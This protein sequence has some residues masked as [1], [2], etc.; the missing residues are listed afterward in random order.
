MPGQVQVQMLAQVGEAYPDLLKLVE[1]QLP[2]ITVDFVQASDFMNKALAVAAAGTPPDFSQGNARYVPGMVEGKLLQDLGPLVSRGSFDVKDDAKPVLTDLSWKG[3]LYGL[4]MDL[5]FAYIAYNKDLFKQAGQTDPGTLWGGGKWTWDAFVAAAQALTTHPGG[6]P[7]VN[8]F[9]VNNWEGD[10]LSFIRSLGGDVLNAD[11]TTFVLDSD[12][13]ITALTDWAGLVT[14]YKVSPPPADGN[15]PFEKV[16][17][18]MASSNPAYIVPF[19]KAQP[20]MAWDL[21][22]YPTLP[23]GTTRPVLFSNGYSLWAGA[24]QQQGA[25][26]VMAALTTPA[27]MLEWAKRTGRTPT[28]TS[29]TDAYAKMLNIPA[30]PPPS[31][32]KVAEFLA[33][34]IEGLPLTPNYVDWQKI[35]TTQVLTPVAKGQVSAADAV[36]NSAPAINA[37]LAKA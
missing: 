9:Q 19:R 2:M 14:K 30:D 32:V 35:L 36:R 25:I 6:G 12:A 7:G 27:M 24:K 21:V 1:Q 4:P 13:G 5:G 37:L 18:A 34:K 17:V 26:E 3:K 29:L 23:G 22:P 31:Y 33:D 8:G 11:R 16:Q 15:A 10:Y 28:R 20:T